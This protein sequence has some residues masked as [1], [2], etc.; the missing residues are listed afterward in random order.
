MLEKATIWTF[1]WFFLIFFA[2]A[3]LIPINSYNMREKSVMSLYSFRTYFFTLGEVQASFSNLL[4]TANNYRKFL[5]DFFEE[6]N[7]W[8][9]SIGIPK[10][11][12]NCSF[13][14]LKVQKI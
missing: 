10:S 9:L 8:A 6:I 1:T 3:N 5:C 13:Y 14:V 4:T 11:P 12:E 2:L 7:H